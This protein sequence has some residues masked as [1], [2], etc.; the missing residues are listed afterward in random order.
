MFI[1]CFWKAI[2]VDGERASAKLGS[3]ES[4]RDEVD[5]ECCKAGV[6]KGRT[7]DARW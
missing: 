6:K 7:L 4:G 2:D 3:S 5:F 1:V